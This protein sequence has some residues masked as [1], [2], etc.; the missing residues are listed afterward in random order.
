MRKTLDE[1]K[2]NG[3]IQDS[4]PFT[5][6]EARSLTLEAA[7]FNPEEIGRLVRKATDKLEQKLSAKKVQFFTHEGVVTDERETE[8]N[9]AQI[10]A[11]EA[12]AD[13]GMDVMALRRRSTNDNPTPPT[14][15]VDLSGW[16]VQNVPTAEES[17]ID[18][19]PSR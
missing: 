13:L 7:G 18:V 15:N 6:A 3:G 16:T 12:L 19:T 9:G 8:D 5:L 10:K 14:V 2:K 1:F 17:T 4:Y 11:A